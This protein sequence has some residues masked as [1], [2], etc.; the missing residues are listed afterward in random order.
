MLYTIKRQNDN[1]S[2]T[3]NFQE[4]KKYFNMDE[5]ELEDFLD[6]DKF[7]DQYALYQEFQEE[8]D[9]MTNLLEIVNKRDDAGMDF[10]IESTELD[11]ESYV[12]LANGGEPLELGQSVQISVDGLTMDQINRLDENN[13]I[14]YNVILNKT[15]SG[16]YFEIESFVDSPISQVVTAT[17]AAK[18]LGI[19]ERGVQKNCESGKYTCRKSGRTWLIDR[20]SL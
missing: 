7:E 3:G 6:E 11:I 4:I 10:Y 8:E 20:K 16:N 17:E 12:E 18:I 15:D 13:F 14:G 2:I 9:Y 1:F 5:P 19:S